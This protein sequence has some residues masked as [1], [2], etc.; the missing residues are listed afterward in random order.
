MAVTKVL[1]TNIKN[2][3]IISMEPD[4]ANLLK[5]G[6]FGKRFTFKEVNEPPEVAELNAQPENTPDNVESAEE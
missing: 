5:N 1:V 6:P 2:R 3:R 4:K